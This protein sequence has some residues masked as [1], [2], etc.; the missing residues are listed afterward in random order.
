[1]RG[2]E[3]LR[4][5]LATDGW[6]VPSVSVLQAWQKQGL[7]PRRR[8]TGGT[9]DGA[10]A[11]RFDDTDIKMARALCAWHAQGTRPA[12]LANVPVWAWVN[13]YDEH[14]SVGQV[15]LA[16]ATFAAA[17]L[18]VN[19]SVGTRAASQL[20]EQ[21]K[22]PGTS[23][24]NA[25]SAKAQ[26]RSRFW[27]YPLD[28]DEALL[29]QITAVTG[30]DHQVVVGPFS[31]DPAAAIEMQLAS[32]DLCRV[33]AVH[34][35]HPSRRITPRPATLVTDDELEAARRLLVTT[36]LG[37]TVEV[38]DYTRRGG[39]V[40]LTIPDAPQLCKNLVSCLVII[41]TTPRLPA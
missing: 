28:T 38:A 34:R 4:A 9:G 23:H 30:R 5:T 6:Q 14:V 11:G 16:L 24:E 39:K 37:Y 26:L 25:N 21:I 22:P 33:L 12:V 40:A 13:G 31:A 35:S 15:R 18:K 1:M 27:G 8:G 29:G 41:R 20:V 2:L 19:V 7:L 36:R 32:L 3:D 17:A 10:T